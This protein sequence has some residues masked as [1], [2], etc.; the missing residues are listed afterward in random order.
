M[1]DLPLLNTAVL[2]ALIF[3]GGFVDS[4][5]GGGGL[6]TLPAYMAAGLPPHAAL[7]T[8]K[9]SSSCGTFTAVARYYTAGAVDLRAG[10]AAAAGALIGSAAGA[11]LVLMVPPGTINIVMLVLVPSAA[12]FFF[13]SDRI[14]VGGRVR[15]ARAHRTAAA[16]AI[17]AAI[18]CYDG[19]FGPGTGTFLAI[20]FSMFLAMDLVNA[21]ANARLTNFA[22]NIGS[23]VIFLA[24]G[25]VLFP[26]ALYTAAAGVAGNW[27]GARL[28]LQKGARIIKPLTGFVIILLLAELIRRLR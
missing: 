7:A 20:A 3:I 14:R 23:L 16:S 5:A 9:F 24:G 15:A 2:C 1:A 25:R 10:L 19:F 21:S 8:N 28:A 17:G 4:I 22:S 13:L 18:G 11:R 26:L 12:L 27:F 6:I